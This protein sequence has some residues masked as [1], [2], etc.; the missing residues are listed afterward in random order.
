MRARR[1]AAATVVAVATLR[2]FAAC[3]GND[4]ASVAGEDDAASLPERNIDDPD[5]T[6]GGGD[7]DGTISQPPAFCDGI[8]FY[9]S[10]DKSYAPERGNTPGTPFGGAALVPSG[11]FAGSASL[12]LDGSAGDG[13]AVY[14]Y[15]PPDGGVPWFLNEKG[16]VSLWYRGPALD[17]NVGSPVFWRVTDSIPPQPVVGG[18]V[19]FVLFAGQF[20]I[21][22]TPPNA[23]QVALLTFPRTSVLPYVQPGAFNHFVT[24]WMRGDGGGPSAL[25]AINGGKGTT[26]GDAGPDPYA[27]ASP[28]DAGDLLVPYRAYRSR[29]WDSDASA[30]AFRIGGTTSSAPDGETD[31][32]AVWNRVLSFDEVSA[33]Y[34]ANAPIGDVCKLH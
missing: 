19:A 13:S 7:T 24:G 32:V 6:G 17:D 22:D 4:G 29:R 25:L 11:K 14:W 33:V 31:D 15:T 30:L 10:L 5:A 9:A 20:G 1:L 28:N 34:S 18:G 2:A 16:T 12:P 27:D 23:G 21:F 3:G 8:V 26:Y